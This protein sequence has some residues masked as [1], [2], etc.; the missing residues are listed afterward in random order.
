MSGLTKASAV[1]LVV[2]GLSSAL[3]VQAIPVLLNGSP[4]SVNLTQNG[5][6]VTVTVTGGSL[7]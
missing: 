5:Q 3:Y 4:S 2:F 7:L 6:I 1:V